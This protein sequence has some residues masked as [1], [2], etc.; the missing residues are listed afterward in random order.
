MNALD[1]YFEGLEK[2]IA[3]LEA[4]LPSKADMQRMYDEGFFDGHPEI[5]IIN[6]RL[7]EIESQVCGAK[8]GRIDKLE[9]QIKVLKGQI[10]YLF[11]KIKQPDGTVTKKH[12][13]EAD[14]DGHPLDRIKIV[15][16]KLQ[17]D[18]TVTRAEEQE[19]ECETC[20]NCKE[21]VSENCACFINKCVKCGEPVGNITFSHC[22]ACFASGEKKWKPAP[23]EPWWYIDSSFRVVGHNGEGLDVNFGWA[24][25]LIYNGNCF[26]TREEAE[27]FLSKIKALRE[28]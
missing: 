11:D 4:K 5:S 8:K 10:N 22:D 25:D 6:K 20:L 26:R 18:G 3:E 17:P 27:S 1:A 15:D 19:S 24:Q 9:E 28:E 14:K 16:G 7:G 21:P 13:I 12:Q 2:R 23:M